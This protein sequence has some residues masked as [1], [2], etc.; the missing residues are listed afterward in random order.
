MK[1]GEW[2]GVHGGLALATMLIALLAAFGPDQGFGG[3][4]VKVRMLWAAF[5][6][7]AVLIST[8]PIPRSLWMT[9]NVGAAALVVFG[10]IQTRDVNNRAN[11]LTQTYLSALNQIPRDSTFVRLEYPTPVSFAKAGLPADL[12]FSPLVHIDS[13]AAAVSHST[14]LSDYEAGSR[15]FPEALQPIFSNEQ[16][17][18]LQLVE[19]A[20]L[21]PRQ[22]L[23]NLVRTLPVHVDYYVIL[24]DA[25]PIPGAQSNMPDAISVIEASGKKQILKAGDPVLVRIF[26]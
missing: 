23:E 26:H 16:Q 18:L 25:S 7:G 6:L 20:Y 1:A 11:V 21:I 17:W 2:K 8:A 4:E 9:I 12:L 3:G 5:L 22:D 14:A 19:A 24:G 15:A 13:Y 10:L